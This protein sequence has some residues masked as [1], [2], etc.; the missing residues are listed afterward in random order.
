M[1]DRHKSTFMVRLPEAYRPVLK[2]FSKHTGWPMTIVLLDAIQR[3]YPASSV[4]KI[5]KKRKAAK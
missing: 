5:R 2:R 4:R 3:V 1:A